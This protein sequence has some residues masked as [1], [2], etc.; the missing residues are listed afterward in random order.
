MLINT[1]TPSEFSRSPWSNTLAYWTL[2]NKLT[3]EV[4]NYNLTQQSGTFTQLSSWRYV[5]SLEVSNATYW[6]YYVWWPDLRNKNITWNLWIKDT[7]SRSGYYDR[8]YIYLV[9]WST[10]IILTKHSWPSQSN[11]IYSAVSSS[12]NFSSAPTYTDTNR[13]NVVC[14]FDYSTK[15]L[16]QYIDK[17]LKADTTL[18][19]WVPNTT[20][21]IYLWYTWYGNTAHLQLWATILEDRIWS[22]EDITEYYNKTKSDY[23]L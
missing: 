20:W 16:L 19:W 9:N 12:N 13:H 5:L 1:V 7:A 4:W 8:N 6:A 15:Q 14:T 18:S 3:D 11:K 23:W 10:E 2:N 21:T 17:E 22:L